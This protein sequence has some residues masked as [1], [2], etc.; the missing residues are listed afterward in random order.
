MFRLWYQKCP[1]QQASGKVAHSFY[2]YIHVGG[3]VDTTLYTNVWLGFKI[4]SKKKIP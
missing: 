2:I 3:G 1:F 4:K